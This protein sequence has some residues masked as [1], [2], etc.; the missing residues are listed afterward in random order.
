MDS[1]I[2]QAIR[3]RQSVSQSVAILDLRDASAS[4]NM[5]SGKLAIWKQKNMLSG[6]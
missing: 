6:K 5:L 4:R 3:K 2:I 1:E